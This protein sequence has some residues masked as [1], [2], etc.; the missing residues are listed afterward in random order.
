MPLYEFE[1]PAGHVTG[2]IYRMNDERPVTV[3]CDRCNQRARRI[4]SRPTVVDDFP[5]HFNISIGEIVKNRAH[6]KQIQK[7]RGLQDYEPTRG[8]RA[9]DLVNHRLRKGA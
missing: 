4:F 8:S 2:K 1:C 3:S 5:E 7:E 9:W 6:L